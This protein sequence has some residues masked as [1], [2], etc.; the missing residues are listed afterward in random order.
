MIEKEFTVKLI[1]KLIDLTTQN[2]IIWTTL[3]KYF[4]ANENEPLRKTVIS[5]NQYAY[6]P[7]EA[8]RV[9]LINE[10]KSYCTA[11]NGG[12]ITLFCKQRENDS[13][14]TI[15][16]Q[17]DPNHYL[18]DL[19]CDYEIEEMLKELLLQLSANIDDGIKFI[20][21]ILNM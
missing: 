1:S 15:S 19:F 21:D 18:Q 17:T 20:N 10:Y 13:R 9:Y 14:L 2:R 11:I 3:P 4:D 5:D 16:I 7:N 8:K 6:T 12:I